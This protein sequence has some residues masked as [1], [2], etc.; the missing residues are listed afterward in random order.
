[1]LKKILQRVKGWKTII[2]NTALSIVPIMQ[3]A[4][5]K[6]VIPKEWLPWYALLVVLANMW[7]RA[8]TTTPIGKS[9]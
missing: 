7:L 1:M 6:A 4:E 2:V 9:S 8:H 5:V 3:L